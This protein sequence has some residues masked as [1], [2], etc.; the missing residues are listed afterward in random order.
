MIRKLSDIIKTIEN[1]G[2]HPYQ[3]RGNHTQYTH[4]LKRGKITIPNP[5]PKISE[6]L[7][8]SLVKSILTQAGL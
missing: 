7:G 3:Q 2:W 1:D 6:Y 5:N 8:S 4:P